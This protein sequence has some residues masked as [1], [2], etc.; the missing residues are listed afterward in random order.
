MRSISMRPSTPWLMLFVRLL[1]FAFVQAL[2][3]LVF[4]WAGAPD[5]W[6]ESAR[7]WI[8]SAILAN[9]VTVLLLVRS[10]RA[11][12]K[13]YLDL[14]RFERSTVWKDLA[15]AIIVFLLA[16]PVGV[17][18]GNALGSLL[19]GTSDVPAAMMFRPLPPWAVLVGLLFPVTIALAELPTYF[20]YAMPRLERQFGS[21]W[22]AWGMASLGL[23]LQHMTLPLILDWRFLLWRGLMFLPFALYIGFILKLRP[24][25]LPYLMVSHFLIDL[26]ALGTYLAPQ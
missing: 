8:F 1:L 23:S 20:G 4:L 6:S 14:V 12:G 5:P 25:L 2:M 11:E 13:S 26:L 19:F 7:W 24:R 9:A 3:A 22:L 10:F 17:I 21:G 16:A 18:P 15:L